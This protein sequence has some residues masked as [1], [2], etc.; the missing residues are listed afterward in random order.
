MM[1]SPPIRNHTDTCHSGLRSHGSTP[2]RAGP[3]NW[4]AIAP[5]ILSS[6]LRSAHSRQHARPSLAPKRSNR[7]PQPNV[8]NMPTAA[9]S[10]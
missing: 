6:S 4:P 5:Q 8:P 3:Q 9:K 7:Q 1:P 10:P 2:A